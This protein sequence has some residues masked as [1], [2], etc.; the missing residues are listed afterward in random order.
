MPTERLTQTLVAKLPAPSSGNVVTWDTELTGLG[1]RATAGGA[2]SFILNYR[3]ASGI[4]RRLTI[5]RYPDWD[6]TAARTEAKALLRKVDRGD[7]PLADRSG[8]R[9]APTVAELVDRYIAEHLP[10]KRPSSQREDQRMI[11]STVLPKLGKHKV[12]DVTFSDISALHREIGKRAK[13]EA[14]R[15]LALLS[16]MFALAVIWQLRADN[17]CRGV[18]RNTEIGRERFL[19]PEEIG[20]LMKALAKHPD[21]EAANAIMLDLL[22]GARRG[23]LL[24][25]TWDQFDLAKGVWI[26][27]SAHTKSNRTHRVPLS[28]A[29]VEL[30]KAIKADSTGKGPLFPSC[31]KGNGRVDVRRPW[32][33][34]CEAA[35]LEGVRFHDLRHSYASLLVSSGLSLPVI[36]R[37]LGHTQPSTTARYA[38]LLDDPLREATERVGQLVTKS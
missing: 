8:Q 27:P 31:I 35:G 15:V 21:R 9:G 5:G 38:H 11:V 10:S 12:T 17:P 18:T 30:L 26:K 24:R 22:T 16:K 2:K 23:E 32:Q 25:A 28:G 34:V 6:V 29:A 36:G 19:E 33:S 37:L 4:E 20:R 14:N 3:N 1:V 7:D 13:T